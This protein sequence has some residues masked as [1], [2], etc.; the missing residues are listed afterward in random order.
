M[1]SRHLCART[2]YHTFW[3]NASNGVTWPEQLEI[4]ARSRVRA[5]AGSLPLCLLEEDHQ[6]CYSANRNRRKTAR[7]PRGLRRTTAPSQISPPVS[8][9]RVKMEAMRGLTIRKPQSWSP[10]P[11]RSLT[12]RN[13][14]RFGTQC[15]RRPR[16]SNPSVQT[17]QSHQ[18]DEATRTLHQGQRQVHWP[19][20]FRPCRL[21]SPVTSANEGR[22]VFLVSVTMGTP[23]QKTP[24][25]AP[26]A[27]E[28]RARSQR[29]GTEVIVA[30]Q[31]TNTLSD[32]TVHTGP[33]DL[34]ASDR[35]TSQSCNQ[36]F[37]CCQGQAALMWRARSAQR[38]SGGI[39]LPLTLILGPRTKSKLK[40]AVI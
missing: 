32:P 26:E 23:G 9:E 29:R 6:P 15:S 5:R 12:S 14:W 20:H 34:S 18:S 11:T 39:Q 8:A 22:F 17:R 31:D 35:R 24:E 27:F 25:P 4:N 7:L 21:L 19:F 37:P 33:P 3:S 38:R 28:E 2:C 16:P 30:N 1:S 40:I 36:P 13:V 10:S